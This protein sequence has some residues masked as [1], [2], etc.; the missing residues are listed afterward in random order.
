MTTVPYCVVVVSGLP[1]FIDIADLPLFKRHRWYVSRNGKHAYA[2]TTCHR[3]MPLHRL[4]AKAEPGVWVDHANGNTLD[5]RRANLR[6]CSPKQNSQNQAV[7][8][9]RTGFKG[10]A[11]LPRRSP[12]F[13]ARIKANGRQL[14]LGRYDT[15]EQ[16]ARAYDEA[17]R[18]FFGPFANVNFPEEGAGSRLAVCGG[19]A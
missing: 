13:F 19:A 15:A 12:G 8:Q 9:S 16:A 1:V 3:K 18:R 4:V 6:F 17:A 11:P 5:N 2:R 14:Y 7:R 10:V